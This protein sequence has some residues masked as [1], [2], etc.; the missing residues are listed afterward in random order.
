MNPCFCNTL[1]AAP[2]A[3]VERCYTIE[4]VAAHLNISVRN[5]RRLVNCGT[6]PATQIGRQYRI[7]ETDLI[8]FI[9]QNRGKRVAIPDNPSKKGVV[10]HGKQKVESRRKR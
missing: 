3:G 8:I 7:Y 2:L 10:E 6:I 9:R 4:E 5:M 1:A